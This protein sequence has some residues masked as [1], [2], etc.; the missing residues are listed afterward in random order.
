MRLSVEADRVGGNTLKKKKRSERRPTV[1]QKH[2]L[3]SLTFSNYENVKRGSVRETQVYND[4]RVE[5]L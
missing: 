4:K 3:R 1:M 2:D 5:I